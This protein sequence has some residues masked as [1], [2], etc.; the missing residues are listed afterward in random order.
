MITVRRH[1]NMLI[2]V[3]ALVLPVMGF[4]AQ[5]YH[6]HV[7]HTADHQAARAHTHEHE[8][9]H[10]NAPDTH[11]HEQVESILHLH[12]RLAHRVDIDAPRSDFE[13]PDWSPAIE[14]L[15]LSIAKTTFSQNYH[16]A[17]EYSIVQRVPFLRQAANLPPP[18]SVA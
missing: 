11:D 7:D 16:P 6:I 10:E 18:T 17:V 15:F 3:L 8:H 12:A 2:L 14:Q 4:A 9:D 5:Q 13:I 1:I